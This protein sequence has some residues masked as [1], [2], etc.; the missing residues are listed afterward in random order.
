MVNKENCINMKP[1]TFFGFIFIV[2][3]S[4]FTRK[5]VEKS[6]FYKAFS[7]PN[8]QE[9]DRMIL[10]LEKEK[11]SSMNLAYQGALYMKKADFEKGAK[12][13][14]EI[15]KKGA[16]I[17]EEEIAK[18][19]SN[20]ELRFL[21]LAIQEHAPRILKYNKN[22]SEDKKVIIEGYGNLD[23]ELKKIIKNYAASSAVIKMDD[24]R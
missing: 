2:L 7:A 21:R 8:E 10:I 11:A 13:K 15:F 12:D 24:L 1:V 19:P 18:K 14:I 16:R 22:L 9:V 4:A 20:A 6:D 23:A 17:L 3:F 5:E